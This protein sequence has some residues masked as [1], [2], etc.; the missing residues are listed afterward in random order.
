MAQRS[1]GFRTA[2]LDSTHDAIG[3]SVDDAQ[4]VIHAVGYGKARGHRGS[5]MPRG[6]LPTEIRAMT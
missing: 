6:F 2:E 5:V 4:T 3:T 1:N